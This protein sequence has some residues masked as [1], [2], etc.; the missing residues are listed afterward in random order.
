MTATAVRH[1]PR[2]ARPPGRAFRKLLSAEA[3]LALRAP[4]GLVFG[5]A[6][7]VLLLVIFG[8]IPAFR[9]PVRHGSTLTVFQVYIPV[10][11]CLSLALLALISLPVP[12]ATYRQLGVLRRFA[13]TPAPPS[14]LLAAQ[15][16]INVVL[17]LVTAVVLVGGGALFYGAGLPAQPGGFTLALVLV[18]AAMFAVGLL[19][20]ARA[21]TPAAAGVFGSLALYP[22]LFFAGLWVP[23]QSMAPVLQRIGDFTPLGAAVQAMGDATQ[24]LFPGVRALLVLA[25]W[26]LAAAVLAVRYFRWE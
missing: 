2:R 16:L 25:G 23:R 12:L 20:T 26:A 1:R 15:L 19:I 13:T 4:V 10:L 21:A 18:T 14:W 8:S 5:V 24:G 17:A 11:I 9:D 22:M 7:P 3:R 6:L